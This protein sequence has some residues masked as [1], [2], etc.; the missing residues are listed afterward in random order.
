MAQCLAVDIDV[1]STATGEHV[2]ISSVELDGQTHSLTQPISVSITQTAE[3]VHTIP[4]HYEGHVVPQFEAY[5]L[6]TPMEETEVGGG[7]RFRITYDRYMAMRAGAAQHQ[8]TAMLAPLADNTTLKTDGLGVCMSQAACLATS[9]TKATM[10][11][12]NIYAGMA[13]TAPMMSARWAR[14]EWAEAYRVKCPAGTARADAVPWLPDGAGLYNMIGSDS[15]DPVD[16]YRTYN[17]TVRSALSVTIDG[18]T[19]AVTGRDPA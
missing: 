9:T 3:A 1:S 13:G 4:L 10:A 5:G 12:V 7:V 14:C 15:E 11:G 19:A 18:A 8:V 16:L 17:H 2:T 6:G